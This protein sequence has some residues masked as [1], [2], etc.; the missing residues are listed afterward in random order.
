MAAVSGRGFTRED[1]RAPVVARAVRA[2]GRA[3]SRA[4]WFVPLPYA[5]GGC[6]LGPSRDARRSAR[7]GAVL[8]RFP[9]VL[10]GFTRGSISG[11][12]RVAAR[13]TRSR[14]VCTRA[15]GG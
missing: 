1:K 13:R 14:L 2:Y 12:G 8:T 9:P 4:W 10:P 15:L 5:Q 7:A 3:R 11:G 6:R